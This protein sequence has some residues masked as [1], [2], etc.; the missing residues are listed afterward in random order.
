M[1]ETRRKTGENPWTRVEYSVRNTG[2]RQVSADLGRDDFS[3]MVGSGGAKFQRGKELT[4]DEEL[5]KTSINYFLFPMRLAVKERRGP[6]PQTGAV[7]AVTASKSRE[8]QI[9]VYTDFFF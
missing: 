4:G 1:K 3:G 5:R 6:G 2:G 8:T 7:I 9:Y